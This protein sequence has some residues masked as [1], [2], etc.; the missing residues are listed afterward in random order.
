MATTSVSSTSTAASSVSTPASNAASLAAANRANAQKIITSLNAGSGVDV[1][2]LA[3]NLVDAERV[4]RENVLNSKISKNESRISGYSAI[5]FMVSELKN[6][7][8]ALKDKN[9]FNVTTNTVSLP[10]ALAVS[11]T[12]SAELG[13]HELQI[14]SLAKPK[15][16]TTVQ[17]FTGGS[18]AL[19]A[20]QW[21]SLNINGQTVSV[22][23]LTPD[24][25][26][27]AINGTANLGVTAKLVKVDGSANP[28]KIVLTGKSAE[29]FAVPDPD[30]LFS[31]TQA[32]SSASFKLDGIQ[33]T[34]STNVVDDVLS[35]VTLTLKTPSADN[36]SLSLARDTSTLKDKFN[37]VV[38]AYNDATDLL[39]E[40]TNP[41][42]T[43]E[44]YGGTL[45]SDATARQVKQQL[46]NLM[47]VSSS[48]P[49][50][51]VSALWQM[52][53]SIDETGKMSADATKLDTALVNKFDDVVLALTG[54][55]NNLSEASAVAGGLFGDASR[56]LG[57]IIGKEGPLLTQSTN[58]DTQNTRYKADLEK[59]Q[60]RMDS[61]LKRYTKQ[62]ASM[63]SLVGQVNSQKT[64][65]KSTF[66]G[67]MAVYTN[68]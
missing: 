53:I 46:R 6:A 34:R 27:A 50:S 58:A 15:L 23:T 25:V 45:V 56:K 39:K 57:K 37:A 5:S 1:N 4:P 54:N 68:K 11:T 62:F 9:S 44:T 7:M 30:G 29:N 14:T 26:V 42:S 24:G 52:G 33:Y 28:Y 21:G 3:Q 40:V 19:N 35:G 51:S 41:K 64:S 12:A 59:L 13:S 43:L 2:T 36:I 31:V 17:G 8:A 55:Q 48:T 18:A 49:G 67:M 65:L 20:A 63:E 22:N 60:T 66:E 10:S 47:T 38:T 61:L 16:V 32:A